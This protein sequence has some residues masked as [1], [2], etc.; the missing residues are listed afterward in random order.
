MAL[1]LI[2]VFLLET[3]FCRIG[4]AALELLTSSDPPASASQSAGITVSHLHTSREGLKGPCRAGP[5]TPNRA[6][7]WSLTLSPRL[8]CSGTILAHC[9][10]CLRVQTEF[11]LL[12]GLECNGAISAHCNFCLPGSSDFWKTGFHHVGQAGVELLTSGD[13]LASASQS[14]GITGMSHCAWPN[15]RWRFALVAQAGVQWHDLGSLQ[16][17]PPRFKRSSCL[18]L[19]NGVLLCCQ[20]GVQWRDLNS[21]QPLPPGFKQFSCLSLLS[22]WDYKHTPP[23]SAN[24]CIFSRDGVSLCWLGW[25]QTPDLKSSAHL[26]LPKCWDYRYAVSLS[27]PRLECNGTISAHCNLRLLGSNSSPASPSRV[28]GI[29]GMPPANFVF[30]VEVGFCHVG[31]AGFELLTSGDPPIEAS[32]SAGIT[33][34][35]HGIWPRISS[36]ALLLKLECSGANTVHCSL[37]LLGSS[38]PLASAC[39]V[40]E[41]TGMCHHIWL[42]FKFFM[43]MG[44]C[45]TESHSVAQDG[46]QWRDLCSLQ[47]VPPR[48]SNSPA[49]ASRIAGTTGTCHHAWLFLFLAQ[50]GFQCISQ[51]GLDL[52]TSRSAHLGLP[53]CWDYR[54]MGFHHVAQAG[55]ELLD[56]SDLPSSASQSAGIIVMSH[57]TQPYPINF[58]CASPHNYSLALS[59]RLEYSGPISAH[60][61]LHLSG[62]SDFPGREIQDGRLA[63]AQECSSQ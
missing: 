34:I 8:E 7:G 35:R 14:A 55:L 12:P 42:I 45:Y 46:V 26:S 38:D 4:Q 29:T 28:A 40:A 43:E 59:P 50:M 57:H 56:S 48:F 47:P 1:G 30:L 39:Q 18:S 16:P 60:C 19:L 2:F 61:S 54:Q 37:H 52:L 24:C 58:R 3:G 5:Y 53:K 20:A 31:Q 15:T 62:L 6:T 36:F 11:C 9:N 51:D 32:Q 10:L 21:L 27:L 23:H 49:S 63:T 33:G 13:P 41:T 22:S 17:P 44:S 25:S